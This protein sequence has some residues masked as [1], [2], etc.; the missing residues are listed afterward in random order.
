M[1]VTIECLGEGVF[2]PESFS[3]QL[4]VILEQLLDEAGLSSGE[5]SVVISDDAMLQRLN[6]EYRD[7]DK[8]TDVLS[9]S[10]L[11]P[12]ESRPLPGED[13]AVGDIY[14]SAERVSLQADQAGHSP[15]R[16]TALLAIHGLLHLVGYGHALDADEKNMREKEQQMLEKLDC[17]LAEG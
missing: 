12:G 10:Y 17:L 11:E 15:E 13:Y 6:K 5:V 16:E 9:F 7:K 14:I 3:R 1:S 2:F 4:E 8:P